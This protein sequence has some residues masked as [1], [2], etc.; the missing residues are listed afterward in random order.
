MSESRCG[1]F[2]LLNGGGFYQC[3]EV[4]ID[5]PLLGVN[6]LGNA[7]QKHCRSGDVLASPGELREIV[8]L[9]HDVVLDLA[10]VTLGVARRVMHMGRNVQY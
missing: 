4:P 1:A 3:P 10:G 2:H 5:Y 6:G 9:V 8:P 7:A